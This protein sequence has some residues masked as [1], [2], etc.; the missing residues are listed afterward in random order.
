[1]DR[2]VLVLNDRRFRRAQARRL[3]LDLVTR[4]AW[5]RERRVCEVVRL[6]S[7][8]VTRVSAR[9][10]VPTGLALA[11]VAMYLLTTIGLDTPYATHVLPALALM[12]V[13][14][15]LVFAPSFSL[16]TLNVEAHDSGVASAAVNTVQQVGGSIESFF[17]SD[18]F[19][20]SEPFFS[21]ASSRARRSRF[22]LSQ[23]AM[24]SR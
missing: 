21:S 11:A 2:L 19:F 24:S 7:V 14:L 18:P 20:S 9:I 17:S 5:A 23:L 12:G 16:S 8:L 6:G 15:G 3:G 22:S 10:L 1:M 4:L 13:G